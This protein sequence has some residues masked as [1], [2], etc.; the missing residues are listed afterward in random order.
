MTFV[1]GA[2][3]EQEQ[4]VVTVVQAVATGQTDAWESVTGVSCRGLICWPGPQ[5]ADPPS[6]LYLR[7]EGGRWW[8]G[9]MIWSGVLGPARLAGSNR[10]FDGETGRPAKAGP[11]RGTSYWFERAG[12]YDP[13]DRLYLKIVRKGDAVRTFGYVPERLRV[14]S[15]MFFCGLAFSWNALGSLRGY[16]GAYGKNFTAPPAWRLYE[17]YEVSGDMYRTG[18]ALKS[19]NLLPLLEQVPYTELTGRTLRRIKPGTLG[20]NFWD[21]FQR[22]CDAA[23]QEAT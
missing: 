22:N 19:S 23:D 10:I 12:S 9:G 4:Y 3:Q 8:I 2:T 21:R 11:P 7:R 1:R 15:E 13:Q 20:P 16:I 14:H 6:G 5:N 18:R 17:N